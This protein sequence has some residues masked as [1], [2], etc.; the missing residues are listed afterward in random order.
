MANHD[1]AR[2]FFAYKS[3]D[4]TTRELATTLQNGIAQNEDPVDAG[5]NEPY[6]RGYTPRR[7]YGVSSTG[8]KTHVP[9]MDPENELWVG[10]TKTLTKDSVV[11]T[12]Q[13]R[14]GEHR[15]V[16]GAPAIAP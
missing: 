16:K 15:Y 6:E 11:Y 10:G 12:I 13:G 5:T 8:L 1:L 4:G 7:V 14:R 2:G 3:D 9:I